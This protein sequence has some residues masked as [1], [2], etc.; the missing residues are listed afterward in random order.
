MIF[1]VDVNIIDIYLTYYIFDTT[2]VDIDEKNKIINCT[3]SVTVVNHDIERLLPPGWS[4]GYVY[5]FDCDDCTKLKTLEGA[6]RKCD[7]FHCC[8]C[9]IEDLIG[10]PVS[11]YS[12]NQIMAFYCED[13]TK[14]KTL[15]GA[16][17]DVFSFSCAGC[18]SLRS[19]KYSPK[20]VGIFICERC[21]ITTLESDMI[22]ADTIMC[23]WC[24]NIESLKGIPQDV[25]D[26]DCSGCKGLKTLKGAPRN[27]GKLS[28]ARCP[29]LSSDEIAK[30]I[31]QAT[32]DNI[33]L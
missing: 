25:N 24:H 30:F 14:L 12:Q 19:L 29:S 28:A 2:H 22:S 15:E 16:P 6:P 21:A 17:S 4:F 5:S 32:Y 7:Y 20:Y 8:R 1:D 13:C 3:G 33:Y 11:G 31:N 18:K 26:I 27:I 10:A 23:S 9:N